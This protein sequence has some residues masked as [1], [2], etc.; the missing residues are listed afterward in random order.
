M[1]SIYKRLVDSFQEQ[2]DAKRQE[3]PNNF[4]V[5]SDSIGRWRII[6]GPYLPPAT[7]YVSRDIWDELKKAI[8]HASIP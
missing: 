6:T 5:A 1:D 7:I 2:E 4:P 3:N 8:N